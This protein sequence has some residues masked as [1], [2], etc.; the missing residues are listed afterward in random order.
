MIIDK[1]DQSL[2]KSRLIVLLKFNWVKISKDFNKN[3]SLIS[4]MTYKLNTL[5]NSKVYF[6]IYWPTMKTALI[7]GDWVL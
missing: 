7:T 2:C 3:K 6:N 5:N 4:G 1:H